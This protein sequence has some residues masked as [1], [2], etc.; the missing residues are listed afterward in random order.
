MIKNRTPLCPDEEYV[1][2]DVDSLFTNISV[3]E[4]IEYILPSNLQ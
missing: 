4:T 3:E 2:Y 1:S